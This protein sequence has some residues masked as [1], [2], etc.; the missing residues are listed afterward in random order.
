[1]QNATNWLLLGAV[2]ALFGLMAMQHQSTR[3]LQSELAALRQQLALPEASA[4]EGQ[5]SGRERVSPS[6]A[7]LVDRLETLEQRMAQAG[8]KSEDSTKRGGT[9]RVDD[10]LAKLAD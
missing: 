8:R 10:L 6:D 7:A 3:R 5:A 2:I 1:M 9:N 4:S